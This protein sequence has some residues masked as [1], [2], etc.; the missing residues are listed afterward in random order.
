MVVTAREK[1]KQPAE[2]GGTGRKVLED[3][4]DMGMGNFKS[5]KKDGG[6]GDL[7]RTGGRSGGARGLFGEILGSVLGLF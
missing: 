4:G 7:K 2:Y 5:V 1:R 3:L 6:F